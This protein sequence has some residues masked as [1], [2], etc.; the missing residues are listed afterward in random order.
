MNNN[1]KSFDKK[2]YS[3][4]FLNELKRTAYA[5]ADGNLTYTAKYAPDAVSKYG[6]DP[7]MLGGPIGKMARKLKLV[8]D[9]VLNSI[10]LKIT[11]RSLGF[12]RKGCDRISYANCHIKGV[13]IKNKHIKASDGFDIPIRIYENAECE[14]TRT[15]MIFIHGGAFVGGTL[16]PYDESLKCSLINSP[17]R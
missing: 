4:E 15:A 16:A 13:S 10:H 12:F 3:E 1:K 14:G 9:F 5:E 11:E 2:W 6:I 17:L 8:P 7:R